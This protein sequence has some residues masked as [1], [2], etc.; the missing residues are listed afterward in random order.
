VEVVPNIQLPG[1]TMHYE[2]EGSGEPLILIPF[3][4]AD[5]ACY[6]FQLADYAK[7]FTCFTMDLR[8]SG[9]SDKP[10]GP[11]SIEMFADDVAAFMQRVGIPQAHISG[12]SLGAAIGMRLASKHPDK[13]KSLSLHSGWSKT[14]AYGRTVIEG[15][16]VMAKALDSVPEMVI[17]AIFPW[18]LTPALYASKP[19]Y[20]Q[21]LADFIRSRPAQPVEAFMDHSNAVI[22]HDAEEHLG[23]IQAPTQI[24]FGR[25]DQLTSTRFAEPMKNGIR[26]SE[27]VVFEECSHGM[28]F[29]GVEEFNTRTLEFLKRQTGQVSAARSA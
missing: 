26:N 17:R 22:A 6:A 28:I 15:W 8:G 18:C 25:H 14:D 1:L 13:V 2:Q 23:R 24:T 12:L 21:S 3:L 27:L 16:Q 9:Q 7:H 20:V 5:H 11:Y 10:P 4:T 19:E 29:E